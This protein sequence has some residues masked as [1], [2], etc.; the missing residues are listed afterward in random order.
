[1]KL[2]SITEAKASSAF[3]FSFC[4]SYF[5]F[6]VEKVK[7]DSTAKKEDTDNESFY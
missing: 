3:F 5:K 6:Y 2:G 7:Q 1:M 4:S